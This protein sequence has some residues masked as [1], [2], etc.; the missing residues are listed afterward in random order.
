M[1]R[2]TIRWGRAGIPRTELPAKALPLLLAIAVCGT[3]ASQTF[4][5]TPLRGGTLVVAVSADP[6]HLN[7]G[8]S[9]AAAVHAV[10]DSM[11][12]GLVALDQDGNPVPDLARSWSVNAAGTRY[13][14]KLAKGAKWHDGA[15]VT[16]ADVRF[17]FTDV[18]LKYHAR[19]RA[20][21]AAVVEAIETPDDET[22]VLNLKQPH[23]A[24]LRRLD[25]TEAPILPR[26]VFSAGDPN[27]NPANLK[28]VGSGP[29]KLESYRKDDSVVLVRND[30]YFKP[31]LPHLDRLVFRIIPSANT[32]VLALLGGEVDYLSRVAPPDV[33][34][35]K[36]R[37]LRLM[38]TYGGAGGA[39][40]IMTLSFN[41]QRD[42]LANVKVRQ[43]LV[44]AIDRR[45]MLDLVIF[46]Q[47]RVASAP[48]S[49]GIRWAHLPGALDGYRSDPKEANQLLDEAGL[50]RG[51][52]GHRLSLD[53]VH[54][55]AFAR[56]SE[57]MRQQL[58]AAGVS[59]KAR[60]QDP[61]AFVTTVFTQRD[62][63]L[64]LISY[65]NGADPEIGVTR[66]YVSSSIG[67]VPFSNA[68]A[69]RSPEIDGLF[70]KAAGTVDQ[71]VRTQA[72]HAIQR[73]VAADLPYWWLVETDFTVAHRDTFQG[74]TPW[75]GQF[76]ERAHRIR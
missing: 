35:L 21:L 20:G 72:Y 36:D 61:A 57:L 6:G 60:M 66:M 28:P 68:A 48:I 10:A 52:D 76:G 2:R 55:P 30:A 27:T 43:A 26:H 18:L 51:A 32:Q 33:Q 14:L 15:P 40:C 11:F 74:F 39:N 29:Y 73:R 3:V 65:C 4:A 59:L 37:G 16:S 31:G 71:T 25:V 41:L 64:A 47:G 46:G 49:S 24:L 58:A 12:N 62:F 1:R 44:A 63:D 53:I 17:S 38:D 8:I 9:T 50:A 7:P 70:V 75:S 69:Y 19:T 5:Q 45:Q 34:R 56:Y 13:E 23:P 22:V 67:T 42:R 54:F